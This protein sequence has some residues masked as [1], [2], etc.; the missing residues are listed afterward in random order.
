[1]K[2][3]LV[4]TYWS[5]NDPL[6]QTYT[7]PYLKI[8]LKI[9]PVR[10]K[11][12]LLCLEQDQYKGD[13]DLTSRQIKELRDIGIQVLQY[14][15]FAF[16]LKAL[17][18][19]MPILVKLS[20]LIL[21]KPIHY[22]HS[23]C[24]PP[25]VFSSLLAVIWRK[26]LIIDSYEPHAES[27]IENGEWKLNSKAYKILFAF[28]KWQTKVAHSIIATTK[29]MKKYAKIKYGVTID[30]FFV[31]PACVNVNQFDFSKLKNQLLSEEL[32]LT[33]KVTLLYAGKF[34][35]I[36]FDKEVFDLIK[37]ASEYYGQDNFRALILSN[38]SEENVKKYC[39]E[40]GLSRDIIVLRFISHNRIQ[41][42]M[43]LADFAISPV[44]PIP[45]KR[46][47]TPIKDGEYWA[48]G[49]PVIIPQN[50]S[51]DSEIIEENEIGYVLKG[52]TIEEYL[53]AFKKM[54]N[55]LKDKDIKT[56]IRQIAFKYRDF[57][58]AEDVYQAI[59]G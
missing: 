10:S 38:I 55:L 30:R 6:I 1:M 22:I 12:Y 59:Y 20:I 41:D 21:T 5:F 52:M 43:N 14:K 8:I 34:G 29:G 24:M 2:N 32:G 11:I 4:L 56:K 42:Y 9:L 37:V 7:L 47:C 48:M 26:P 36:Y 54:D 39:E 3:I 50:I 57:K 16:G 35:G 49:L 51:D 19:W 53:N 44:K 46:Y 23:W 18:G 15:Y 28:E 31:K 13:L 45:T 25:G 58:V 27:N 17:M 33:D 40:A